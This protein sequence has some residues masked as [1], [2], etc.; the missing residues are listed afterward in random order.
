L[1]RAFAAAGLLA[2]GI[3]CVGSLPR[4]TPL[5]AQ[6]AA[7]RWPDA[8]LETLQEGRTLYVARCSAC[9]SLHLP[10]EYPA[11]KWVGFVEEMASDAKLSAEQ[12]ERV[13]QYLVSAAETP[14]P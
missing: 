13:I 3:G 12:K 2:L 8:T 6:R 5:Q 1:R 7:T 14:A 9:H 10:S 11:D 4:P